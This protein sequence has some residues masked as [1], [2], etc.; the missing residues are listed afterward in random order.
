MQNP[1]SKS[2]K[3]SSGH[4]LI[5]LF[6]GL[7]ILFVISCSGSDFEFD[8]INDELTVLSQIQSSKY[9][10]IGIS[11]AANDGLDEF[12]FLT[13]TVAKI[14]KYHGRFHPNLLPV[15]EI[16]DDFGFERFHQVYSR[17]DPVNKIS[18]DHPNEQYVVFWD[19]FKTKAQKGK[20]YRV[21]V[22]VGDRVM[23]YMDVGIVSKGIKRLEGGLIPL[24]ENRLMGIHF[25][26]EEKS[27]PSRIEILPK[28]STIKIGETQSFEAKVYNYYG[29]L[30][31][32]SKVTWRIED[33]TIASIDQN[34]LVKGSIPG[35][36]K[37]IA[38]SFDVN[39]Y[40]EITILENPKELCIGQEYEGGI[41][42][43]ILQPGDPGYDPNI[44]HGLIAAKEDQSE[45]I[46]FDFDCWRNV[47]VPYGFL[48]ELG[49]GMSNTNEIL[50]NCA[51]RPIASS[52]ASNYQ[53]GSFTDW[54][55]P[56]LEELKKLHINKKLIG[57]FSDSYYW[58]SSTYD[59]KQEYAWYIDFNS[60][61]ESVIFRRHQ[62][63]VRAIRAF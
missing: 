14:P 8:D 56:S 5:S 30:L 15:V 24:E 4:V 17:I 12:Y 3:C 46:E 47:Q 22:R 7:L 63:H 41:V 58:S 52:V 20:I 40:A 48:T 54:F 11:D 26:L 50:G 42:A 49:T 16:S 23:G 62:F 34:G 45:S 36:T 9:G 60:G 29:E 27:C 35:K 55:L 39:G 53:S 32:N 51:D 1:F 10:K 38:T 43:Y 33:L 2:F 44:V 25:R 31:E 57:G 13:P 61:E 59:A 18:V 28:E 6:S 19:S 21:R 37:V